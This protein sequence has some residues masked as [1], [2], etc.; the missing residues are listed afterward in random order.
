MPKA[1]IFITSED[2]G[3]GCGFTASALGDKAKTDAVVSIVIARIIPAIAQ[4]LFI[5]YTL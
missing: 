5:G 3:G 4:F 1:V 2:G